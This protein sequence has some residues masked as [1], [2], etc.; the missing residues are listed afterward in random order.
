MCVITHTLETDVRIGKD[1]IRFKA[2]GTPEKWVTEYVHYLNY[3][4]KEVVANYDYN[5]T[6]ALESSLSRIYGSVIED[7]QICRELCR[8]I[9]S[10]SKRLQPFAKNVSLSL[11]KK[12]GKF[13]EAFALACNID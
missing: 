3:P 4:A 13:P 12:F 1:L 11:Y 2:R 7:E 9:E 6:K 5:Q 8:K 10:E